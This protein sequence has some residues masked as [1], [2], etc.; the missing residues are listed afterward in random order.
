MEGARVKSPSILFSFI[1][2]LSVVLLLPSCSDSP[3]TAV[4]SPTSTVGTVDPQGGTDFL[5]GAVA[6]GPAGVRV[7]VWVSN[8]IVGPQTVSFDAVLLNASRTDIA[9]PLYFIITE[10]RA[11]VVEASNPDDV[12]PEG[13]VYDFSDDV[14]E[15]GILSAGEASAPVTMAFLP[16][17]PR[18]IASGPFG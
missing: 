11:E 6:V 2:L 7:E 12:G 17:I 13:P 10:I 15:D 14:G 4:D 9:G 18:S 16:F 3:T 1:A 8:L 5:L